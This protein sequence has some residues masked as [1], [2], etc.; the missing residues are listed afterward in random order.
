VS[1]YKLM[2]WEDN[3]YHDSYFYGVSWNDEK[4]CLEKQSLGATAYAGGIGFDD[5]FLPPT[6]EILEKA[7]KAL[8]AIIADILLKVEERDVLE[9]GP[10]AIKAGVL[11]RLLHDHSFYR[12]ESER[13][14]KCNGTGKWINPHNEREVRVCSTCSGEGMAFGKIF[15]TNEKEKRIKIT[16]QAGTVLEA[17][18][19]ADFF[20]TQYA[21]GY[22]HPNRFN[23]FVPV[24]YLGQRIRI[25]LDKLRLDRDQDSVNNIIKRAE[26]L[27]FNHK[28]GAAFGM[29][30]WESDNW[31]SALQ[32]KIDKE[33]KVKP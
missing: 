12:K 9:P 11:L 19:D 29:K 21:K 8:A 26:E 27:S 24:T 10:E 33:R 17:R 18:G 31:A 4:N 23:T 5:T 28:Y 32:Q 25:P 30:A 2:W 6:P 7:R 15:A 3:G 1:N 14:P 20:G 13:C 16:I 22:N